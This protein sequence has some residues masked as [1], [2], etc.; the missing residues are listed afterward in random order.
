MGKFIVD[1]IMQHQPAIAMH[2]LIH[3]RH[4]A[5][6]GDDDGHPIFHA[7]RQILLQAR[8]GL[9]DDEI[10][11]EGGVRVGQFRAQAGQP[12]FQHAGGTGIE[13]GKG[14][15]DAGFALRDDQLRPGDDEHRR[16]D[17]GQR[18]AGF[19][20]GGQGHGHGSLE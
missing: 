2:R 20:P 19:Q 12:L 15:D 1:D 10:D 16:G 9:V 3:L 5:E 7:Q 18:Q 11:R 14:P 17:G 6:R 4:R 13:R 8:I